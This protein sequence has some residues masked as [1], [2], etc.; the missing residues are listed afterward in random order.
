MSAVC[1]RYYE[2]AFATLVFALALRIFPHYLRCKI[3]KYGSLR[4]L[5]SS[6]F[7][8]NYISFDDLLIKGIRSFY[9]AVTF[10]QW[11]VIFFSF[12]EFKRVYADFSSRFW[13]LGR[14]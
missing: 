2:K 14:E 5:S 11:N 12:S 10:S 7:K 8:S 6:P 1:Q 4:R 9:D 13:L 3:A